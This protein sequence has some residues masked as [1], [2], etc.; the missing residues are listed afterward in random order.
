MQL[1]AAGDGEGRFGSSLE[2]AT[3]RSRRV[4]GNLLKVVEDDEAPFAA[5]DR[6]AKLHDRIVTPE[7]N[8]ERRGD[9]KEHAL[10]RACF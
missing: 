8:V 2:P 6:V 1:L 4:F 7:P 9:G 10:E 3:D 5:G